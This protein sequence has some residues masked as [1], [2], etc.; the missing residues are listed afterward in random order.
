MTVTRDYGNVRKKQVLGVSYARGAVSGRDLTFGKERTRV[1]RKRVLLFNA[2]PTRTFNKSSPFTPFGFIRNSEQDTTRTL[3][4]GRKYMVMSVLS[5]V[6]GLR[7]NSSVDFTK[8]D[9]EVIN[10]ISLG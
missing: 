6:K 7:L 3:T 5:Q 1:P 4:G 9:L 8:Q 10:I 2:S